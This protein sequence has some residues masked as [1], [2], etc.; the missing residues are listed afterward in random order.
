MSTITIIVLLIIINTDYIILRETVLVT[1]TSPSLQ[2]AFAAE[3]KQQS[4]LEQ[5][6]LHIK[7]SLTYQAGTRRETVSIR[8]GQNLEPMNSAS[9]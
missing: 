5:Q 9:R 7:Y 1:N 3:T 8:E 4:L 6:T 2:T